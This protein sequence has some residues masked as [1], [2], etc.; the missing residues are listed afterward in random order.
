MKTK[1]MIGVKF[2]GGSAMPFPA[3]TID[4]PEGLRVVPTGCE[5]TYWLDEFPA[6]LFPKGSFLLHDAVHYGI[7]LPSA[8]VQP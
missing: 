2:Q 4:I 7:T 3:Y 6:D 1:A 5:G 8:C